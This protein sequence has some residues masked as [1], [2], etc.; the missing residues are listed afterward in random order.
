MDYCGS[1]HVYYTTGATESE[2]CAEGEEVDGQVEEEGCEEAGVEEAEG[3]DG[4]EGCEWW[5]AER[6]AEEGQEEADYVYQGEHW[7]VLDVYS[8]GV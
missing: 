1:G 7:V 2:D 6:G 5:G 4:G 8:K 3:R